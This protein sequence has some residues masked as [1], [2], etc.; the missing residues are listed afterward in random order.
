MQ[1]RLCIVCSWY[2]LHKDSVCGGGGRVGFLDLPPPP[3][4]YYK[5]ISQVI[6]QRQFCIGLL[7]PSLLTLMKLSSQIHSPWMGDIVHSDRLLSYRHA[8]KCS[9]TGLYDN[10]MPEPTLSPQS[11]TMNLAPGIPIAPNHQC[12][13]GLSLRVYDNVN[14]FWQ[15]DEFAKLNTHYRRRFYFLSPRYNTWLKKPSAASPA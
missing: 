13:S 3:P 7:V 1:S 4:P 10:P 6:Q 2:H 5:L 11:G 8:S 9:L 12:L 14:L 15:N